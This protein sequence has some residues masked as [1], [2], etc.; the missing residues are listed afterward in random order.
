MDE[1]Q[2]K[3]TGLVPYRRRNISHGTVLVQPRMGTS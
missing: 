1:I 2:R 3:N